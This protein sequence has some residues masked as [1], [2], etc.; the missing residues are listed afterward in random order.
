MR[1]FC[2]SLQEH[3]ME[4]INF[5]KKKMKLSTK[6]QQKS[7]QNVKI[8]CICKKNFEDKHAKEKKRCKVI[9]YFHYTGEHWGAAHSKFN[10]KY[11]IPKETPISFHNGSNYDCHLIIKV[12]AE[13]FERQFICLGENTEKYTTFSVSVQKEVARIDINGEEIT[14]TIT[15][16]NLLQITIYW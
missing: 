11:S 5:K 1:K 15:D 16:N 10:S 2:E 14:K 7:Y 6:K 4:K 8:C 3:T 12:L 9:V 13:E